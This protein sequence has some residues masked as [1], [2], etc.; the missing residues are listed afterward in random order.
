MDFF[1]VGDRDLG[2]INKNVKLLIP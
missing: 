2:F 1:S